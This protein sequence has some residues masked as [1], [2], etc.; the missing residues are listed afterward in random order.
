MI[1]EPLFTEGHMRLPIGRQRMEILHISDYRTAAEALRA[2][3]ANLGR[4]ARF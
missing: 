1:T 3:A 4:A 2:R